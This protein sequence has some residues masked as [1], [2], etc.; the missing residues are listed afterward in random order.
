MNYNGWYILG[1]YNPE[2][3][4]GYGRVVPA[5]AIGYIKLLA[6]PANP[7]YG[8]ELFPYWQTPGRNRKPYT[9]YLFAVTGGEQEILARGKQIADQA[10]GQHAPAAPE[11]TSQDVRHDS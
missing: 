2:N 5:E 1:V 8:F 3:G 7:G 6:F 10:G 11:G 9:T 4:R